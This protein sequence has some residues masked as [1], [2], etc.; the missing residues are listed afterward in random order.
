M[1]ILARKK[2][3]SAKDPENKKIDEKLFFKNGPTIRFPKPKKI[4]RNKGRPMKEIGIKKLK[5]SSNVR[6]CEIQDVPIKKK[7]TPNKYP[8][9]NK[10][11]K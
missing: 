4:P 10:L 2:S 5:F 3:I 9:K 7:P 8:I 6:A 11:V 1:K